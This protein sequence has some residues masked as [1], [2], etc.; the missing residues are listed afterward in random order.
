VLKRQY[1]QDS[2]ESAGGPSVNINGSLTSSI[3]P[4]EI[5]RVEWG[6]ADNE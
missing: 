1:V 2:S 4:N 6:R 3:N 5:P